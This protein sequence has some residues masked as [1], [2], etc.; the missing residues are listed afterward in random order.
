MA[1]FL[2]TDIKERT[3]TDNFYIYVDNQF[4]ISS[5]QTEVCINYHAEVI[6]KRNHLDLFIEEAIS[7]AIIDYLVC[8]EN[9]IRTNIP[10]ESYLFKNLK[11]QI[12]NLR[13]WYNE[14]KMAYFNLIGLLYDSN[15]VISEDALKMVKKLTKGV[16]IEQS[17]YPAEIIALSQIVDKAKTSLGNFDYRQSIVELSQIKYSVLGDK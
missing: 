14:Q 16:S 13:Y 6:K 4:Y 11:Q 12:P 15:T 8:N 1:G 5:L 7:K 17:S 9:T 10:P 2:K 3:T